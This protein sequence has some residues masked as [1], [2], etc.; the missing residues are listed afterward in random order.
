M[1]WKD[2]LQAALL[3][4]LLAGLSALGVRVGFDR[5]N[6]APAPPPAQP[7]PPP[8]P[9]PTADPLNAIGR[10]QI[11]NGGCSATVIHPRR[12]DGR[13]NIL[14]AAHCVSRVGETG[15]MRFRDGRTIG[16]AVTAVDKE[17]DCAWL[18]SV[19]AGQDLPFAVL[20]S[21]TPPPGA[22][23]WHAGFGIDKPANREN[24]MLSAGANER[25]ML[26][27]R[28]SVSPGDSGGGICLDAEGHVLSPV[29]CTTCLGCEGDV[30]GASPERCR[31]LLARVAFDTFDQWIPKEMPPPPTD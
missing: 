31:A 20:A 26:R 21:A 15:I 27:Y 2:K 1:K 13:W 17:S 5:E 3:A 25:G 29:C 22:S 18:I 23:I 28:L 19:D 12:P 11:G 4:A 14:T 24:G 16:I 10:I 9:P 6:A 7:T 30:W 8:P